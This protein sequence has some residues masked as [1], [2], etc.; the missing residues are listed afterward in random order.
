[1]IF[2]YVDMTVYF[3]EKKYQQLGFMHLKVDVIIFSRN[4]SVFDFSRLRTTIYN[5]KNKRSLN[6]H[7]R[8][9]SFKNALFFPSTLL[10]APTIPTIKGVSD[11]RYISELRHEKKLILTAFSFLISISFQKN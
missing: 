2:G 4:E 3:N 7:K 6:S 10:E 5:W 11:G 8:Y 1:V 9:L